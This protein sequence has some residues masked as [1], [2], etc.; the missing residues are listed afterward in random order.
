MKISHEE[1][2]NHDTKYSP[3]GASI[4]DLD[5]LARYEWTLEEIDLEAIF[6]NDIDYTWTP[7][8]TLS[9]ESHSRNKDPYDHEKYIRINQEK[10]PGREDQKYLNEWADEFYARKYAEQLT[11][12]PAIIVVK[13]AGRLKIRSG[14]HRT[15]A[16]FLR[17]S[18][19]ILAYV[20]TRIED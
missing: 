16:A 20:G 6:Y 17:G 7:S 9:T 13:E 18:Q 1:I 19:R 12:A 2:F 5:Q 15:R 11:P 8:L 10:R 14:R 3:T 4:F